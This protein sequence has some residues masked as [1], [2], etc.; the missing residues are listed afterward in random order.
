[1][2]C[3]YLCDCLLAET[4]CRLSPHDSVKL[5]LRRRSKQA[6]IKDHYFQGEE[7]LPSYTWSILE[8][9][10]NVRVILEVIVLLQNVGVVQRVHD[11]HLIRYLVHH[12]VQ[13]QVLLADLLHC[14]YQL[15][16][17]VQNAQHLP[18]RS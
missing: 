17:L 14:V 4:F 2:V 13:L 5:S 3:K 10:V 6:R 12:L 16:L 8:D 11:L 15:T 7:G 9:E 1:M 18:E